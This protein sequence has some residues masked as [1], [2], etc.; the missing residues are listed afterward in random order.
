M[1]DLG[2]GREQVGRATA[3]C[4]LER[5]VR[6]LYLPLGLLQH[7]LQLCPEQGQWNLQQLD[8]LFIGRWRLHGDTVV[9]PAVLYTI[10]IWHRWVL[11]P[12][13]GWNCD[14]PD[15]SGGLV[16]TLCQ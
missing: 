11:R 16:H 9:A 13:I 4:V 5:A 3:G 15:L 6:V 12:V 14:R 2:T 7:L 1:R 10:Q 8:Q